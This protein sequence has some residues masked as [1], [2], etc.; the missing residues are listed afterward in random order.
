[1][2]SRRRKSDCTAE[3][4][5]SQS[6][7]YILVKRFFTPRPEPF[8]SDVEGRLRGEISE[9]FMPSWGNWLF[10]P[11]PYTRHYKTSVRGYVLGFT[12]V[13]LKW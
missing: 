1:M 8:L 13:E 5:S 12:A 11:N 3:T 9:S 2:T 10:S 7:E 6:S 4:G